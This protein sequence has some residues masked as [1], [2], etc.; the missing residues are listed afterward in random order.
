MGKNTRQLLFLGTGHGMPLYSSCASILVEDEKNN[1]LLD[2]GGGHDLLGQFHREE[3]NPTSVKNIFITHFDSDHIL[4]IVPLVRAFHRWAEPV[5]RNIF[6][7]QEVKN[8]IESL[9]AFVAKDHYEPVKSSFNFVILND[10][11]NFE[12]HGSKFTFFDIK[13]DKSPQFGC[14]ILFSDGTKFSFLGDE[15]LREHYLDLVKNSD[16]LIHDAFCLDN[17][18]DHFKPHPK[19]HS[20][21]KEA[22]QNAS[23]IGAK[24]LVFYHMEDETLASRKKTYLEEAKQN[25]NGEIFVPVDL[26]RF[27]F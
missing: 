4:C 20:T 24:K 3:K 27:E 18:Q 2:V 1:I 16:V 13:S 10:G 12:D 23:R 15:P 26:D 6:C 19:N 8:A 7:S 22:A 9:F 14:V 25:F 21:V 17:Q 5:T 11:T